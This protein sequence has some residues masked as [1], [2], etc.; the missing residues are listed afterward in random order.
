MRRGKRTMGMRISRLLLLC[1]FFLCLRGVR[2]TW[3]R[4]AL[5]VSGKE[6]VNGNGHA[7]KTQ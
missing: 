5:A 7:K 3:S 6:E 2:L 4:P 1:K